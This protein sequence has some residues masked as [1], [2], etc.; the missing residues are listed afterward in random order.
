MSIPDAKLTQ[1]LTSNSDLQAASL[2]TRIFINRLRVEVRVTPASLDGKR[3]E[4]KAFLA[5]NAGAA[6]ELALC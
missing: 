1:V 2:G 6:A 4:L 5:R 3:D